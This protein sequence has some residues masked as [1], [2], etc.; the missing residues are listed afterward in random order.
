MGASGALGEYEPGCVDQGVPPEAE[1]AGPAIERTEPV[2][3]APA[4]GRQGPAADGVSARESRDE[5]IKLEQMKL[6]NLE[7]AA[8]GPGG[9]ANGGAGSRMRAGGR[10]ARHVTILCTVI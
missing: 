8:A 7:L 9:Y 2:S 10:V 3:E 6:Q 1:E 4:A 5:T